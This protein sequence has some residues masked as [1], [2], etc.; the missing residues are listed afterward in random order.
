MT[1]TEFL[2][3][4]LDEDEADLRARGQWRESDGYRFQP[5]REVEAKRRIIALAIRPQHQSWTSPWVD[6]LVALASVYSDHPAYRESWA[7]M[8]MDA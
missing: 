1:L 8:W 2:T 5:Q 4:R 3:A 6:A 7:E